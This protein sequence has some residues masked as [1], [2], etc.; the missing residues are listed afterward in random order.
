MSPQ[1]VSWLFMQGFTA[2]YDLCQ[3]ERGDFVG[4]RQAVTLNTRKT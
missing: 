1:K 4:N 2:K 3:A